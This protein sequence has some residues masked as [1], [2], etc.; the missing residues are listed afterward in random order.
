MDPENELPSSWRDV[1]DT[2]VPGTYVG[3]AAK[4]AYGLFYK[5]FCHND[6]IYRIVLVDARSSVTVSWEDT[7]MRALDVFGYV[8]KGVR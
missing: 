1:L 6:H 2:K 8:E 5:F 3:A 7:G 4:A